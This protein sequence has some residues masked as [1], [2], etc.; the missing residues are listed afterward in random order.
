MTINYYSKLKAL[1]DQLNFYSPIHLCTC[2]S[3]KILEAY[4]DRDRTMQLLM[5]LNETYM[6]V[7]G[8]ILLMNPIS[9]VGKVFSL[10]L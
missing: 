10:L 6:G 4:K 9:I 2:E 1:W 3:T 5:G 7:C 8:Q